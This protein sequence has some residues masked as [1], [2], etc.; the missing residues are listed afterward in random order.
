MSC[1]TQVPLLIRVSAM[2]LQKMSSIYSCLYNAIAQKHFQRSLLLMNIILYLIQLYNQLY[3][4][5]CWLI[6]FICKFIPLKRW[7]FDDSH[8]PY[9]I[10]EHICCTYCG[11][12][13]HYPY[14][15]M[16]IKGSSFAKPMAFLSVKCLVP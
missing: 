12:P 9:N 6:A 16:V 14:K 8:S 3:R 1:D 13:M 10:P 7:V 11:A 5:N 2:F 4:Q 15:T